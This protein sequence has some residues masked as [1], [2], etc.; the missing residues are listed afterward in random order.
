M[1]LM[2]IK[3]ATTTGFLNYGEEGSTSCILLGLLI[4]F[5]WNICGGLTASPLVPAKS[6]KLPVSIG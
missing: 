5:A 3:I 2:I 4:G 1:M 6:S